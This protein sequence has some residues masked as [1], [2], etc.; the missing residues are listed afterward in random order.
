MN[1]WW[2]NFRTGCKKVQE[3]IGEDALEIWANAKEIYSRLRRFFLSLASTVAVLAALIFI[4]FILAS[5]PAWT[6]AAAMAIVMVV[7]V[8]A[9]FWV[10]FEE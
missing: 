1:E 3:N 5:L 7:G 2:E 6:Y 4:G 10:G 8:F 9:I